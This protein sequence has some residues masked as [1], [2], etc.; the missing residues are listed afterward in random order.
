MCG[1]GGRD[2]PPPETGRRATALRVLVGDGG[3]AGRGPPPH[4]GRPEK[5]P[6]E[7][8]GTDRRPVVRPCWAT[9]EGLESRVPALDVGRRLGVTSHSSCLPRIIRTTPST[10]CGS[11]GH[12][13]YGDPDEAVACAGCQPCSHAEAML[14][15]SAAH[16]AH[17]QVV[18]IRVAT[19]KVRTSSPHASTLT[20][21]ASRRVQRR[22]CQATGRDLF[23]AKRA[24]RANGPRFVGL[25]RL[26]IR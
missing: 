1:F 21:G 10:T 8:Y 11:Q 5:P 13:E 18:Q 20:N 12:L 7:T 9:T 19:Q 23:H 2:D 6:R 15:V 24:S 16:A 17:V 26:P 4:Q 3:A 22:R 25:R 14:H